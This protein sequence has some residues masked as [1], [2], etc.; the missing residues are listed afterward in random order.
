MYFGSKGGR[1]PLIGRP[2]SR[3]LRWGPNC[4]SEEK[5]THAATRAG[6]ADDLNAKFCVN[7]LRRVDRF[8]YIG[9]ANRQFYL[10]QG[11]NEERLALAPYCVDNDRF[12]A[13]AAATRPERHRI[14]E[15]WG[16]PADAFCFLFAGKFVPKKRPFDLIEA[17]RRIQRELPGNKIHLLWVGSGE[18]GAAL[19]QSCR[20][21]FDAEK[22]ISINI[23]NERDGPTASF[24]GFLNQSE[25][26]RAYVAADCLVLPSDA[27]E[28]WGLVVNEAMASGLPCIVSNACGCAEDL[29]QPIRPDL[30]YPLGD[31]SALAH[32]MAAAIA[33]SPPAAFPASA[34]FQIRCQS[35]C[36]YRGNS[37][38]RCVGSRSRQIGSGVRAMKILHVV[39]TYYPATRYGGPIRSVHGLASAQASQGHDIHVYTTNADGEG[40][41]PV[42]LDRPVR[43]DG[44]NVWYFATSVGRRI[45]WS[46][47]MRQAL[48]LNIKN[49][50][51]LHLHS[52]FLWP[53][54]MA[55]RAARKARIPYVLSPRGMLVGDLIR[56]KSSLAKR[57]WIS[58]FE[59]RNIEQAAAI[60]LTS[61]TEASEL[62][63]LGLRCKRST[64]VPNG[65]DL[66]SGEWSADKLRAR[67]SS[68]RVVVLL[69][70]SSAV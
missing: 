53:T 28:T 51:I 3:Q 69:F 19:R 48:A 70:Y 14:R 49:F 52:V 59:R 12:A 1:W 68:G 33:D 64:V 60:H 31:I 62:R 23:S 34:N 26:S 30:C 44:V 11:I 25:I 7:L 35:Y 21:C 18:L 39:P 9:E 46:P 63:A 16:I 40:V 27:T 36:R 42:P 38:F 32:A 65:V 6:L 56:R 58:L 54:T 5:Q 45:Y 43:L 10:E 17:A 20:A 67:H 55:A 57:A 24:V 66:P 47:K 13:A 4:G 22:E 61:E 50:D 37:V 15:E 41:L 2:Y 8:L 29:V